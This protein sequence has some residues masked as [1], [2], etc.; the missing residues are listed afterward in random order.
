[1][2]LAAVLIPLLALGGSQP[3]A[4]TQTA[5]LAATL[6]AQSPRSWADAG[7]ANEDHIVND[8]D[9]VPLRYRIRKVD[10][11]G[12]TTREVIESRDGN[13]ARMIER[14]GSPLTAEENFA[15]RDRLNDLL[16]SPE[17]FLRHHRRDKAALGYATEL[18]RSLPQAMIWTYAPGQPQLPANTGRQVV[19]DFLPDPQFKPPTLVTEGLTALAGRVW[20]DARTHCMIRIEGR[21]LRSVDFGWGGMLARVNGGGT[22]EFEQVPAGE[23]RWLFSHLDEHITVRE[24][25]IHTVTEDTK[26]SA[27]NPHPLPAPVSFQDAIRELLAMPVPAK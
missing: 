9:E 25:M 2:R 21:I 27:W 7:T 8:K 6:Y 1:M 10:A 12:D 22:V 18:I 11:K 3:A 23:Q 4:W 16:Q 24:V 15:E 17:T 20:L 14:N 26:M 5:S 19:L 13:V